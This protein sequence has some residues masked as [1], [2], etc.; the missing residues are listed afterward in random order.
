MGANKTYALKG[1]RQLFYLVPPSESQF[2]RRQDV[3]DYVEE[4]GQYIRK[5]NAIESLFILQALPYF[6]GAII[7][8]AILS[9]ITG[10]APRMRINDGIN[11]VAAGLTSQ[12]TKLETNS[13]NSI[14]SLLRMRAEW[15]SWRSNSA[16]TCGSMNA[17]IT[18]I[19]LGIQRTRGGSAF[20]AWTSATISSTELATVKE[21]QKSRATKFLIF[22]N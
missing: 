14:K 13:R 3:P 18:S 22:K 2:E 7:L 17:T 21:T 1:L 12:M 15:S 19:C 10:L 20:S 5:I 11:S 16:P 4:V 8:E 6:F 9:T